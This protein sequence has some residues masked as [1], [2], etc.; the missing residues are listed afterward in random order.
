MGESF[1]VK[2]V[3]QQMVDAMIK[4][5]IPIFLGRLL[6]FNIGVWRNL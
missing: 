5:T 1:A 3:A 4:K 2:K 6:V